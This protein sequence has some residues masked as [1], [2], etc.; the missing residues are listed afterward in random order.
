MK[1]HLMLIGSIFMLSMYAMDSVKEPEY[2]AVCPSGR[3]ARRG[4][5]PRTASD[6]CKPVTYRTW[7]QI[8]HDVCVDKGRQRS[9]L[10]ASMK[11]TLY[12]KQNPD[13]EEEE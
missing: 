5:W 3:H 11:V 2:D 4:S 12:N 13:T 7:N 6:E 9:L 8:I 10:K 1:R